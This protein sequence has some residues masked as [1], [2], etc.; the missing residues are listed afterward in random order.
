MKTVKEAFIEARALIAAG[1][2]TKA[3]ARTATGNPVDHWEPTAVC[4]CTYGA[5]GRAAFGVQSEWDDNVNSAKLYADMCAAFLRAN[6]QIWQ[7]VANWNDA[8]DQ[9]TVLEAF[10]NAVAA[11]R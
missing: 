8:S 5:M 10:D 7:G 11:A 1:W 6:P 9:I 2:T 3:N 4:F